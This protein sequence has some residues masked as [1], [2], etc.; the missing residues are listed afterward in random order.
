MAKTGSPLP[1]GRAV[2]FDSA[3]GSLSLP[4]EPVGEQTDGLAID[5]GVIPFAH[6]VEIRRAL[7]VVAA[8]LPTIGLEQVRGGG[9]HVGDA[10]TEID[11]AVAVEVDAVLDVGRRQELRLPN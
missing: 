3:C 2:T 6:G 1:R 11:P 5:G 9:Q 7:V 8:G 10:V 4:A